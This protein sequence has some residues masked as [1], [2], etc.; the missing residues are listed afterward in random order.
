MANYLVMFSAPNEHIDYM[1]KYPGVARDYYVGQPPEP[2][3]QELEKIS[4]IGRLLGKKTKLIEREPIS[5]PADWPKDD[6]DCIDIEINHRN[7]ELYHWIL[8]QTPEPVEGAGSIFQTWFH[9]SHAAISLD[10][11]NEDFAF[12]SKQ[13]P[14]LLRLVQNVTPKLLRDSFEAWCKANGKDHVPT[15]EEAE[16]MYEEFVNFEKYLKVAISKNHGL[17]WVVS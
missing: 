10:S 12:T 1:T 15:T 6:A 9:S 8:N 5:A 2:D 7:V 16:G 13:L 4:F 14:E 17:V 3:E 11:Y